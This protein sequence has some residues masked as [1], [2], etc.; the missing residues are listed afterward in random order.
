MRI[1]KY[2]DLHTL[3]ELY[4]GDTSKNVYSLLKNIETTTFAPPFLILSIRQPSRPLFTPK[5]VLTSGG[6]K[7][8]SL[9]VLAEERRHKEH[10]LLR[11]C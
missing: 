8:E 11:G 10:R 6:G 1:I 5:Y 7:V 3:P 2:S 9:E 4:A